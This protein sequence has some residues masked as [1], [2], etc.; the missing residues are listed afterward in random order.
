MKNFQRI[1]VD[2]AQMGDVPCIRHL[3]IPV[4]PVVRLLAGGLTE[5]EILAEYADLEWTIF[6]SACASLPRQQSRGNFRFQF[7][8]S[9]RQY[10]LPELGRASLCGYRFGTI[11]AAQ[12]AEHPS[13]ILPRETNL[14]IASD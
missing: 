5:R 13:F 6:Q 12:E 4:A 2:P 11:L 9:N 14:L 7:A 3:R 8:V 10:P 1:T